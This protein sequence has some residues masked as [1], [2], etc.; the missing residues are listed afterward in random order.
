MYEVALPRRK[1]PKAKKEKNRS[2][3]DKPDFEEICCT[4]LPLEGGC[5]AERSE[6]RRLTTFATVFVFGSHQTPPIH[7][8]LPAKVFWEWR[9]HLNPISTPSRI[10]ASLPQFSRFGWA[11]EHRRLV[12]GC[13]WLYDAGI[14]AN[15]R[16]RG[17][18]KI[19][20]SRHALLLLAPLRIPYRIKTF[21]LVVALR[22]WHPFLDSSSVASQM[23]ARS[24]SLS[25]GE[26]FILAASYSTAPCFPPQL[27]H[28]ARVCRSFSV[29]LPPRSSLIPF[30]WLV[31]FCLPG[32]SQF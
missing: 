11:E 19:D 17:L 23:R 30:G 22:L 18:T 15:S 13:M 5:N 32:K 31:C 21:L 4:R 8:K 1:V 6:T 12:A 16:T 3:I 29:S 14:W 9:D 2:P 28:C 27:W 24:H 20:T 25:Q 7:R 10:G 26:P